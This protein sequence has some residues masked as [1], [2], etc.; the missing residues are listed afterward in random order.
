MA[1]KKPQTQP[2]E[3]LREIEQRCISN[4]TGLPLQVERKK[5]TIAV[6]F[7]IGD[8]QL[9]APMEQVKE[10]LPY[11]SVSRVP[12]TKTWMKGIAN[13]RGMLL[14]VVD[15]QACLGN[16]KVN[17]DKRSRVLVIN[18][19]DALAGLVVDEVQGLKHFLDEEYSDTLPEIEENLRQHLLG[20]YRQDNE[21]WGIFSMN[22]LADN[23]QFI[24]VAV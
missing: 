17:I 9:V 13:V 16:G 3:L 21:Q 18:C 23:P 10:I 7:R 20:S 4:A 1:R 12:R 14:P 8:V 5:T 19:Q 6:A 11:P 2:L 22:K 15:L 24:Q